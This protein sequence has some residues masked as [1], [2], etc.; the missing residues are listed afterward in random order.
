MEKEIKKRVY[1]VLFY[2]E[3]VGI[4]EDDIYRLTGFS[5]DDIKTKEDFNEVI[6]MLGL[7]YYGLDK[8]KF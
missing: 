7:W 1:A 2:L 4:E 6:R 3:D 5:I 8:F